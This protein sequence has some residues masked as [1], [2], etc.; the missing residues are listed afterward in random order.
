MWYSVRITVRCGN[1]V[2]SITVS[3]KAFAEIRGGKEIT[4][5]GDGFATEEIIVPDYWEFN[6]DSI[7]SVRV[8]VT[9][10]GNCVAGIA[11]F[12]RR[13]CRCK[14]SIPQ[15]RIQTADSFSRRLAVFSLIV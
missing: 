9:T 7:G 14:V 1:G 8:F 3:Q 15:N 11:G 12:Q 10:E 6:T 5:Q 4:L 2:H 13:E